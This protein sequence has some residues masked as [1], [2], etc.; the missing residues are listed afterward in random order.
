MYKCDLILLTPLSK[1]NNC[2]SF[3]G[4]LYL[5]NSNEIDNANAM[6]VLDKKHGKEW[7][8][9]SVKIS[10]ILIPV[11]YRHIKASNSA[12]VPK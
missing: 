3:C 5:H 12:A 4:V 6:L 10:F 1:Q 7:F 8:V 11:K 9:G 2:E